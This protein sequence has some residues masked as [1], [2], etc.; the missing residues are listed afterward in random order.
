[1]SFSNLDV[2]FINPSTE[3]ETRG[4]WKR[5]PP[6]GILYLIAILEKNGYASQLIDLSGDTREIISLLSNVPKPRIIGFTALTNT[7]NIVW[8]IS[9]E[10]H[11]YFSR[12]EKE[13]GSF[14]V[15]IIGGPHVSFKWEDALRTGLVDFCFI[16]ES[17]YSITPFLEI[18][19][20]Q[21]SISGMK[22]QILELE[23]LNGQ[24]SFLDDK[25]Q[26]I[27]QGKPVSRESLDNL[28]FPARYIPPINKETVVHEIADIIVNR[29]CPNKCIFCSR[30][31]LFKETRF[32][33]PENII[34]EIEDVHDFGNYHYYNL[35]DNLTISSRFLKKLLKLMI[36]NDKIYLPWGAELRVDKLDEEDAKLLNEAN[37][38][39]IATGIESANQEILRMAGK[40]QSI[41][42]VKRGLELVKSH[43]IAVQAYFVVGLPGETF[44][45]F[46]QTIE[47]IIDSALEPG[48]DK[49]DF[50][51]AT[52]YPGSRLHDQRAMLGIN[53]IDW[54]LDNWDCQHIVCFPP[55]LS[56]EDINKMWIEAKKF[57]ARFNE[58]IDKKNLIAAKTK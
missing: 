41:E 5:E 34:K 55:S 26:C 36:K 45:T 33:S 57:E 52:P 8:K 25:G 54:N 18:A 19:L 37:C 47:F 22:K 51:A 35:Y 56:E 53:V 21:E 46:N 3:L 4:T 28:P 29:G 13:N 1:M 39:L 15:F 30:Q 6:I 20:G 42:K 10:L 49:I 48:V 17:E 58:G 38:K 2:L 24:I 31:A 14:P 44:E 32:R 7:L 16:G 23:T 40:F 12:D 11:E 43:D 27:I 9:R 50:F